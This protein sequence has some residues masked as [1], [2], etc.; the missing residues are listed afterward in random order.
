[1]TLA[2]WRGASPSLRA[3]RALR[4]GERRGHPG[5]RPRRCRA[6]GHH[7]PGRL[8]VQRLSRGR[9]RRSLLQPEWRTWRPPRRGQ[10]RSP[11]SAHGVDG[12]RDRGRGLFVTALAVGGSW[13]LARL[14]IVLGVAVIAD[15]PPGGRS[16]GAARGAR[17]DHLRGRQGRPCSAASGSSL[18]SGVTLAVSGP[19]LAVHLRGERAAAVPPDGGPEPR[20]GDRGPARGRAR[21]ERPRERRRRR[22]EPA[23]TP[24]ACCPSRASRRRLRCSPRSSRPPSSSSSRG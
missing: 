8:A 9:D 3:S 7:H 22:R 2:A 18:S 19:L 15:Q 17:R 13:R 14:L 20:R 4:F 5:A 11:R 16:P 12:A 21:T 24:S 6:R 10:Q 23:S 1:M